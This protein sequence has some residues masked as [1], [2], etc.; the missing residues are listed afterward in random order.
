MALVD[1][2]ALVPCTALHFFNVVNDV[3]CYPRYFKW[4]KSA[5]VREESAGRMVA[6]LQLGARGFAFD[7]VTENRLEVGK[8][9]D[10]RLVEGPF[11]HLH[12]QWTF[13]DVGDAGC[14][15]A[16]TMDFRPATGKLWMPLLAQ[17]FHAMA[18]RMVDDFVRV[19]LATR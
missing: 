9:I 7:L 13:D 19:A 4:C 15:V 2:S 16:L 3:R 10:M 17:G 18:D 14:R 8:K 6:R 1:K 11:S 5:E 12:G